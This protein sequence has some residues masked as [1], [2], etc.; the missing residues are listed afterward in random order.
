MVDEPK[1]HDSKLSPEE[2][3]KLHLKIDV[4]R[5]ARYHARRA[6]FL[7]YVNKMSLFCIILLGSA[8][9]SGAA[10]IK[11]YEVWIGLSIA[12]LGSLNLVFDF[13]GQSKDHEMLFARYKEISTDLSRKLGFSDEELSIFETRLDGVLAQEKG[14]YFKALNA[15]CHNEVMIA[16]N[17][18]HLTRKVGII[19]RV[20]SNVFKFSTLKF[21]KTAG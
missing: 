18:E 3:R 16:Y 9:F 15:L 12:V 1:N 5:N 19:P 13:A 14:S 7:S 8:E 17:R 2:Q 4:E 21:P 11:P 6:G 20:F 10:V